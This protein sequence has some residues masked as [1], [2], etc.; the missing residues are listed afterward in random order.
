MNATY[1]VANLLQGAILHPGVN[2]H[3]GANCA[4]KRGLRQ[5]LFYQKLILIQD[6][7][8]RSKNGERNL[9][10]ALLSSEMHNLSIGQELTLSPMENHQVFL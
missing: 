2:L 8:Y 3:Q 10:S 9:V 1:G 5:R 7:D 4:Y 6:F